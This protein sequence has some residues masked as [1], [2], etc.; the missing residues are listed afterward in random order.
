MW[1]IFCFVQPL[2]PTD[3]DTAGET[4]LKIHNNGENS[5][6]FRLSGHRPTQTQAP[7]GP[8]TKTRPSLAK[9]FLPI[10]LARAPLGAGIPAG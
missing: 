1:I 2:T 4:F 6:V 5:Q 9:A 10:V 7:N 3:P 8:Y